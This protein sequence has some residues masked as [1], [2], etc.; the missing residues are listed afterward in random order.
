MAERSAEDRA[1]SARN[2]RRLALI[3][4][5]VFF[6]LGVGEAAAPAGVGPGKAA[7]LVL[8]FG[9][10]LALLVFAAWEQRPAK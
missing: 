6:A 4:A 5:V 3:L 1:R 9:G 10:A 8:F 7:G 2:Q